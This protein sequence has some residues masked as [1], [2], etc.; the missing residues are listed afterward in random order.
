MT[1]IVCA[2]DYPL[3]REDACTL[4]SHKRFAVETWHAVARVQL[5]G[6]DLVVV[7]AAEL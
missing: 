1:L 6:E 5:P 7:V 3:P 4:G 2:M